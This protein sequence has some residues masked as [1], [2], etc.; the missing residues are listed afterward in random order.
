MKQRYYKEL[1]SQGSITGVCSSTYKKEEQMN[2]YKEK[3]IMAIEIT[4]RE[5]NQ[6]YN[7]TK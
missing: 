3:G 1:D 7:K 6:L 4:K 2:W 5:Y